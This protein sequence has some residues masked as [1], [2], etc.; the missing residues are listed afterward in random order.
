MKIFSVKCVECKKIDQCASRT[1]VNRA[2]VKTDYTSVDYTHVYTCNSCL[3][4]KD[5]KGDATTA[6]GHVFQWYRKMVDNAAKK[7]AARAARKAKREAR[8]CE[9]SKS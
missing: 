2:A 9:L 1:T 4:E 7:V 8:K 3:V 6:G 5:S